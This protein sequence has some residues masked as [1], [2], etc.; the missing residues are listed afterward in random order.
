MLQAHKLYIY[1]HTHSALILIR[2][3]QSAARTKIQFIALDWKWWNFPSLFSQWMEQKLL[4]LIG[5]VFT[6]HRCSR[7]KKVKSRIA[8][9]TYYVSLWSMCY[10]LISTNYENPLFI[11][12]DGT[13][14]WQ[15]NK[16]HERVGWKE[17]FEF[18]FRETVALLALRQQPVAMPIRRVQEKLTNFPIYLLGKSVRLFVGTQAARQAASGRMS[19]RNANESGQTKKPS[20]AGHLEKASILICIHSK[21]YPF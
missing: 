2:K 10:K 13:K 6:Q 11:E 21:W 3:A 16:M 15:W 4:F 19:R 14:R 8:I 5:I 12:C 9:R 17:S 20:T 7:A 18:E 1:Q